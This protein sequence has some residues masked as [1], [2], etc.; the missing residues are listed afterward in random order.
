MNDVSLDWRLR[1]AD[2]VCGADAFLKGFRTGGIHR[3]GKQLSA[4]VQQGIS[5]SRNQETLVAA[6]AEV[7]S[8]LRRKQRIV[9][10]RANYQFMP[11]LN[12][13]F[14]LAAEDIAKK[15]HTQPKGKFRTTQKPA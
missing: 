2:L 12:Q 1:F 10:E 5:I 7:Q 3:R 13:R 8:R 9:A 11:M 4:L 14:P 6:H 15:S